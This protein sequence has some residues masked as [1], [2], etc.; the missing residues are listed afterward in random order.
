MIILIINLYYYIKSI[1][2]ENQVFFILTT[3]L[4]FFVKNN[5]LKIKKMVRNGFQK[6]KE[7]KYICFTPKKRRFKDVLTRSSGKKKED[8]GGKKGEREKI[9]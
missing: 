6:Q 4:F 3:T 1:I 9:A 8:L 5:G 2:F 7:Q